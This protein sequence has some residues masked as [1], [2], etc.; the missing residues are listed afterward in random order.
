MY[1]ETQELNTEACAAIKECCIEFFVKTRTT[2]I[3][4][5]K[6]KKVTKPFFERNLNKKDILRSGFI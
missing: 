4:S 6:T 3:S 5:K 1:P 2:A